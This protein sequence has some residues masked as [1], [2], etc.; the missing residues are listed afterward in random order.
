MS[1][2]SLVTPVVR[3]VQHAAL[4]NKAITLP[5][6]VSAQLESVTGGAMRPRPK[7]TYYKGLGTEK[8]F[9]YFKTH[10][11]GRVERLIDSPL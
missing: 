11:D 1:P 10:P 3:R 8:M 9:G 4:M 7:I 2:H 5:V 6:L